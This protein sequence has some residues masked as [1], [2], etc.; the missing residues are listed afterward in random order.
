MIRLLNKLLVSICVFAIRMYQKVIAPYFP[1]QCRFQPSCS[2]YMED[3]L[4]RFGFFKG[5]YLGIKRI[6]RCNPRGKHG[7]DPVPMKED[8]LKDEKDK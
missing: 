3:S 4:N 5:L 2:R 6:L 1:S 7:Y 8:G